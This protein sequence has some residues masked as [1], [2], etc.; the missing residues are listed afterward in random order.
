M[1]YSLANEI[2]PWLLVFSICSLAH[3]IQNIV[4]KDE[5][6]IDVNFYS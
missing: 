4:N 2:L 1:K 5:Y 3:V 6:F